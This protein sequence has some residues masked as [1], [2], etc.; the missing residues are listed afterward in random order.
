MLLSLIR[1]NRT[2]FHGLQKFLRFDWLN[3]AAF[4]NTDVYLISLAHLQMRINL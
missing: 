2:G 1:G 3:R 4:R